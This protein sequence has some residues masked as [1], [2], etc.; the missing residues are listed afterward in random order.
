MVYA[1]TSG[2]VGWQLV[3]E[4]PRRRKGWG[5]IPLP[6]WDPEVGWENTP[7]P[8]DDMPCLVNPKEGFV[9]TANSQPICEGDGPFLG[10]DWVDGYRLARIVERLEARHDWDV[11]KI[12]TLQMDQ[13][14][15]PWR[16]LCDI[17]KKVSIETNEAGEA[18]RILAQWDG[19]VT[20]DSAP[21]AVFEF[22][23]AQMVRRIVEVRA[24]HAVEQALGK[25]FSPLVPFCLFSVRHVGRLVRLIQEQ[26]LEWFGHSWDKEI[27]AALAGAVNMLRE[28]CGA[29]PAQWA[30]GRVRPLTLC[31]PMGE[32]FPL[33]RV[34]NLGPL[35]WAGDANTVS[36]GA[37]NP[38]D[39]TGNPFFV[40]SLRMVIDVGNWAESR[41]ALP[42][43][44]SGNPLSPHYDDQLDLWMHGEG[45]PIAWSPVQVDQATQSILRLM[46]K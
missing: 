17:L 4:A 14:S 31:H 3:G 25:G 36:Q 24:P 23:V 33:H 32:R 40:A 45:I 6:G 5:T 16:E 26:P 10:T 38:M 27:D 13:Q 2:T 8:F 22:F 21:A 18:L 7:V 44:Q 39:P 28:Q 43:G 20:S 1:E 9:A 34:F 12:Q 29:D 15:L 30:W 42:G 37:V 35:H 41:F 46:P 19:M 11:N